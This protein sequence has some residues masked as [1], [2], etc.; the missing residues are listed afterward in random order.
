[1]SDPDCHVGALGDP[2]L[3]TVLQYMKVNMRPRQP[4]AQCAPRDTS[5]ECDCSVSLLGCIY[6]VP[7]GS[8]CSP[9]RVRTVFGVAEPPNSTSCIPLWSERLAISS[10]DYTSVKCEPY[11][12]LGL[13]HATAY[14]FNDVSLGIV[15]FRFRT[16]ASHRER[17]PRRRIAILRFPV[18]T[19]SH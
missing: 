1:M 3:D 17:V 11:M 13:L 18:H 16:P 5:S 12:S 8:D 10:S 2:I 4:E 6:R 7:N 19:I 14:L 9:T 15:V